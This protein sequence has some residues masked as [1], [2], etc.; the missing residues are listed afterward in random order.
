[1]LAGSHIET[2]T[3]RFLPAA[4]VWVSVLDAGALR[5]TAAPSVP[6]G[7]CPEKISMSTVA[8]NLR[9]IHTDTSLGST[10]RRIGPAR[11]SFAGSTT[12]LPNVTVP[13]RDRRRQK[14]MCGRRGWGMHRFYHIHQ[15]PLH[16]AQL[17]S[18]TF[19]TLRASSR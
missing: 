3:C 11:M 14:R 12:V 18:Q 13:N 15:E 1:M 17:S 8:G 10:R 5:G 9:A 19:W 16:R 2:T 7:P 6:A 4:T